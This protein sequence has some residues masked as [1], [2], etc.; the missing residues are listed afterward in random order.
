MK[1]LIFSV[2]GL[3]IFFINISFAGDSLKTTTLKQKNTVYKKS[4]FELNF[5]YTEKGF[6]PSVTYYFTQTQVS[7]LFVNLA[8]T[9]VSDGRE[10]TRY[11]YYGNSYTANKE[12]RVFTLPLSIG[13]KKALFKN[14][15]EGSIFPTLSAGI[16]PTLVLSNPYEENF[17]AAL[18]H[19]TSSFAFG[20]FAG[21]G[22][23]FVQDKSATTFTF[24][25]R[26]Y[27][28]KVLGKEINSLFDTP[29][30]NVG[31]VQLGLGVH[32]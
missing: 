23:I 28:L 15:I 13:I 25:L 3:L 10:I 1:R 30:D 5:L 6:G 26:Y 9:S 20:P 22:I 14:D 29:I 17:F 2:L 31:G 24:D 32:F 16:A 7:D 12:N 19:T 21:V 4:P 27:Y 11:D 18:G 8:V